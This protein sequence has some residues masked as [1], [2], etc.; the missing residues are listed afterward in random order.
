[1]S[2]D[3]ITP[4][5]DA[6]SAQARQPGSPKLLVSVRNIEE[7]AAA[8]AGGAD[9]I[10]LKEP[11]AGPLGAVDFNTAQEVV[12]WVAGRLP[13]SAALGELLTWSGS[14]SRCLLE[15]EGIEVVKLGL[16]GCATRNDWPSLWQAAFETIT[17]VEKQLVAV[18]YADWRRAQAPSPQKVVDQ[19]LGASCRYLLV[20]T[21]EKNSGSV[22]NYLTDDELSK[23]LQL[24]AS[25]SLRIVIAGG[26]S[27][28]SLPQVPHVGID[29]IAVRGGV[30]A[31]DRTA[32][33]QLP[34]VAK[35]REAINDR[36][37]IRL[38]DCPPPL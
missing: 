26:L 9:W 38:H 29:L 14:V 4:V 13:V 22:F 25:E 36:W 15:V 21:F 20:D 24:A 33:V 10:D 19:A 34:L 11:L 31:G 2:M 5:S 17:E 3:A 16:A 32:G 37:S 18:V 7:A 12:A 1:M 35:F 6:K 30:C 28:K 27:V 8:L 23:V